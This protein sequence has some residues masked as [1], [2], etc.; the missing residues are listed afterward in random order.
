MNDV[1]IADFQDYK[2]YIKSLNEEEEYDNQPDCF[3]DTYNHDSRLEQVGL[4][5]YGITD[6]RY[7]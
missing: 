1:K 3:D 2:N 4:D 7:R 6:E 5:H